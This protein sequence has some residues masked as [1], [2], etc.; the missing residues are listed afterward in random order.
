MLQ[1]II[2]PYQSVGGG[3]CSKKKR[4][5]PPIRSGT[6]LVQATHFQDPLE[7]IVFM[8][9]TAK[10][11]KKHVDKAATSEW[12]ISVCYVHISVM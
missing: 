3:T 7:R 2:N 9:A 6:Y 12:I 11:P 10:V 1:E 4:D 8:K 5:L